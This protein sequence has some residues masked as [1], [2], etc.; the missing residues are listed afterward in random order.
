MYVFFLF[1]ANL[2][3]ICHKWIASCLAMTRSGSGAKVPKGRPHHTPICN[4]GSSYWEGRILVCRSHRC[5]PPH[6]PTS[7]WHVC[8]SHP[9]PDTSKKTINDN[10]WYITGNSCKTN[11]QWQFGVLEFYPSPCGLMEKL[12]FCSVVLPYSVGNA[13]LS[14]SMFLTVTIRHKPEFLLRLLC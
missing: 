2:T 9:H 3:W 8:W 7:A 5:P 11:N 10:L 1:E 13:K 6:K 4:V 14:A 12:Y